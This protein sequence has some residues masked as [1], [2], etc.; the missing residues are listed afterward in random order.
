MWDPGGWSLDNRHHM[1]APTG[2]LRARRGLVGVGPVEKR[3]LMQGCSARR[4]RTRRRF[5]GEER[6]LAV[7]R[8]LR[9]IGLS[10]SR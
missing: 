7:G 6:G 3:Q 8:V 1:R 10:P 9:D 2:L 4:C 5:D